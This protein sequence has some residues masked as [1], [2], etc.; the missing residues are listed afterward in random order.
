MPDSRASAQPLKARSWVTGVARET[1]AML[2]CRARY[3]A[4]RG[5]ERLKRTDSQKRSSGE[6]VAEHEAFIRAIASRFDQSAT[7][8]RKAPNSP[9]EKLVKTDAAACGWR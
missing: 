1:A 8:F 6:S 4:H 2:T 3:V 7:R 9:F 5:S